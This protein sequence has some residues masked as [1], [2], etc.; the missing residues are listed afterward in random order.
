MRK[1]NLRRIGKFRCIRCPSSSKHIDIKRI[2]VKLERFSEEKALVHEFGKYILEKQDSALADNADAVF[3]I[4]IS[5]GSMN[6]ALYEGL[7]SDKDIFP[8]IKWP[9]WRIFFCDERLVP[10]EDPQSNYGQFKKIVLDPLVH[11]GDQLNLGPT[12]YTINESLIGGGET[13]NKKIAEE[14]ASLLPASFDLILLG[15][16]DDGHTCSLFP[17]VEYNYLVEEMARKVLW[18]YNSPKPPKDRITFTLAVVADAKN[19]AFLVKGPSKKA[20]MHDVLI[21]KNSELPS[22]LV[23]EIVG[24]KVTWFLDDTAGALIPQNC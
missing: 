18:C 7:V 20:I 8:H 21:V 15:C 10:F 16:G 6:Q 19:V 17:G 4:A 3:N 1:T 14:Y 2:M 23:N 5:G 12:V 13:A 22:V 9:Q 11:Q 24:A